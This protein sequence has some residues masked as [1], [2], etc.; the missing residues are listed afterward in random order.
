MSPTITTFVFEVV[1]FLVLVGALGWLFFRPVRRAIEDRRSELRQQRDEA[2]KQ[3]D[4]AQRMRERASERLDALEKEITEKREAAE[5]AAATRADEILRQAREQAGEELDAAKA[6][7]AHLEDGQREHLAQTV[8]KV[9][10]EAVER[11]LQQMQQ[12][13]MDHLMLQGVCQQLQTLRGR[14]LGHVR[15]E[16]A[17]PLGDQDRSALMHAIN[18]DAEA[19]EFHVI[20]ELGCGLRVT[21]SCGLIDASSKGLA[22]FTEARL[23]MLL[24]DQDLP[25]GNTHE[26]N[27]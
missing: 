25:C 3:L 18:D 27:R 11:L 5:Q 22:R 15:I 12:Q 8:A 21:T 14:P 4:E 20:D 10:G 26:S 16:S 7:L 17:R 24:S 9:A 13:S 2:Q 6:R 23:G 1:N 19:V